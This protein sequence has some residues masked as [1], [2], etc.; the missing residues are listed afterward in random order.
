MFPQV[1]R[2]SPVA[3]ISRAMT[4]AAQTSPALRFVKMHGLGNDFVIVDARGVADPVTPALARALGDRHRGVGFDQLAV[5]HDDP[6]ETVRLTFW[7]A[8]GSL[9]GACGNAT[10]CVA[11]RLMD[12]TGAARVTLRTDFDVLVAEDAGDRLTRVNM[13]RPALDWQNVPLAREMDTLALPLDGS[14]V[15]LSMG[16][17][18]CVFF[19]DDAEN[20][21]I[22]A[23][24][25]R[26]ETDPLY[27]QRTNVEM[28]EVQARDRLRLRIWERGVGITLASGS[29]ACAALVAAAR[30]GLADR[31]A[32]VI[33]DGGTLHVDWREDGVWITGPTQEVFEGVLSTALPLT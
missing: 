17:P 10:R 6:T 9:S 2:E 16:N 30:R 21:D 8:D 28:V 12:E 3:P 32:T 27:P 26:F 22:T 33:V 31:A 25:Q 1:W 7:N 19:T 11:R 29:C 15:A 23:Q 4:Q 5:I 20:A 18:H 14:P 13:G 24:G